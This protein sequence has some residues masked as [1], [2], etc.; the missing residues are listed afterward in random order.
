MQIQQTD[1]TESQDESGVVAQYKYAAHVIVQ[2]VG[3]LWHCGT[4]QSYLVPSTHV[5][6]PID[7]ATGIGVEEQSDVV[8]WSS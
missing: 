6:G 5:D 7:V 3:T 1:G 2:T 8:Y 4:V